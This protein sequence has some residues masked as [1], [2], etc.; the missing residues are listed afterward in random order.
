MFRDRPHLGEL[1][2][3]HLDRGHCGISVQSQTLE[4]PE[5]ERQGLFRS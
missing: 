2:L 3:D 4:I 5:E 1:S